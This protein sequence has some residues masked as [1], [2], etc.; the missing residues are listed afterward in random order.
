MQNIQSLIEDKLIRKN[1]IS[2]DIDYIVNSYLNNHI[3]DEVMTQWLKAIF[4]HGM[5]I[6]E[7]IAYTSSIFNSG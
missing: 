2:S 7:T 6:D 3:S 1:H 4:N 5:N